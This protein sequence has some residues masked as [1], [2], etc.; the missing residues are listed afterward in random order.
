MISTDPMGTFFPVSG[1][2]VEMGTTPE[3]KNTLDL[4]KNQS[5]QYACFDRNSAK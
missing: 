1:C 3:G 4:R 2:L 5:P